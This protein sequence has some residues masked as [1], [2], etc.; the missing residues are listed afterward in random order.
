MLIPKRT[1]EPFGHIGIPQ[2]HSLMD[3]PLAH[4]YADVMNAFFRDLREADITVITNDKYE[5]VALRISNR[6]IRNYPE[7]ERKK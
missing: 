1:I 4:R 3:G 6:S 7:R 5:K 2:V